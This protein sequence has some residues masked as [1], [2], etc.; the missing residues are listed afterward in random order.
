MHRYKVYFSDEGEAKYALT[1]DMIMG[2]TEADALEK[3]GY[4]PSE[5]SIIVP[6]FEKE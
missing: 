2:D 6:V 3:A 4:L 1:M 5:V